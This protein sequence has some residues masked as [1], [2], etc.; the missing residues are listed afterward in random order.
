MLR[1]VRVSWG[2]K[3]T[4]KSG[5]TYREPGIQ[6]RVAEVGYLVQVNRRLPPGE[7]L[8]SARRGVAVVA[9]SR[10]GRKAGETDHKLVRRGMFSAGL[11]LVEHRAQGIEDVPA[12]AVLQERKGDFAE[13]FA[14]RVAGGHV[15][16]HQTADVVDADR[17][18]RVHDCRPVGR[19]IR[20]F[21][22]FG[23]CRPRQR[24]ARD[25]QPSV[26][27]ELPR[28]TTRCGCNPNR[29]L[30]FLRLAYSQRGRQ[31]GAATQGRRQEQTGQRQWGMLGLAAPWR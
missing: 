6:R 25:V 28:G 12:G 9:A 1:E 29:C 24:A 10:P 4:N 14:R 3:W 16:R 7:T 20:R 8:C 13:Q 18:D 17:L 15:R 2:G 21:L 26:A 30:A 11:R 23:Q 19:G 31:Q 27:V 5:K 22:S